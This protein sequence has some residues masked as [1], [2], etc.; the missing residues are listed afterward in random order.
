MLQRLG[1]QRLSLEELIAQGLLYDPDTPVIWAQAAERRT[2]AQHLEELLSAGRV[3]R[4][5]QGRFF[6]L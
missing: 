5:E 1:E 2:I 4:D 6:A 3:E